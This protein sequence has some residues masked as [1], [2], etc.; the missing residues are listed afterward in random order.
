[1]SHSIPRLAATCGGLAHLCAA[2]GSQTVF[3]ARPAG[4]IRP[5]RAKIW[6]RERRALHWLYMQG[7]MALVLE[8]QSSACP[9][10]SLDF[11]RAEPLGVRRVGL[12]GAQ[13]VASRSPVGVGCASEF[14]GKREECSIW[15]WLSTEVPASVPPSFCLSPGWG[16]GMRFCALAL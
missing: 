13:S 6:L 4:F 3:R 5:K 2:A 7:K 11:S 15:E 12:L 16:I 9:G 8:P 10:F 1:M 14:Q